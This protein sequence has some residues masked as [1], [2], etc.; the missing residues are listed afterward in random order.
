M[1]IVLIYKYIVKLKERKRITNTKFRTLLK[2]T[3]WCLR[4]CTRDYQA[5]DNILSLKPLDEYIH[6]LYDIH[7]FYKYYFID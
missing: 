5:N 4:A 3:D 2:E 7:I 6:V 1:Y